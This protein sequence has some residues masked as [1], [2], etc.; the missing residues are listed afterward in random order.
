MESFKT[1]DINL[2]IKK[3]I[4]YGILFISL[5]G[6]ILHSVYDLS[7]KL[8]IIGLIAPINESI[9]EHLK[10][11]FFPTIICGGFILFCI[12]TKNTNCL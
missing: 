2:L 8:I 7:G 12:K 5:L 11:A 1:K 3:N 9:W 4:F 10:L 6:C